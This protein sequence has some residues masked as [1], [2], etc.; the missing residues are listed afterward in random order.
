[1]DWGIVSR[2]VTDSVAKPKNARSEIHVLNPKQVSALLKVSRKDPLYALYYL[3]VATGMRQGELFA[4]RW[5]DVDFERSIIR[6]RN[7]LSNVTL[8][9]VEVKTERSKRAIAVTPAVIAEL[10][11]HRERQIQKFGKQIYVFLSD[12][13]HPLRV[14]NVTRKSWKPLLRAANLPDM[15]F[16]D[17]RHTS[18][19][20][21][22]LAGVHVKVVSERLGHASVAFTMDTYAHV[23]PSMQQDAAR[24]MDRFL[25]P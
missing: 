3:A 17:L 8:K 23:L 13:G 7:T 18:A 20:L 2:N 1:M 5:S 9:P 11:E 14:S 19:T 6:V 25:L 24:Q 16:H 12:K 15:R 10:E 4:L 22:L 21:M